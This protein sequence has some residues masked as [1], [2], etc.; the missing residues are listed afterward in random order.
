MSFDLILQCFESGEPEPA[1]HESVLNVLHKRCKEPPDNYGYYNVNFQDGS[2]VEFSAKGLQSSES[3]TGCSF[4]IR[5][6]SKELITFVYE[7]AVAGDMVIFNAQ[8]ADEPN[9]PLAL[10]IESRQSIDL[11]EGVAA[12]PVLCDSPSHLAELI[13]F[14]LEGWKDYRDSV[15]RKL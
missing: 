1:D 11:P 4:H 14:S 2:S 7:V 13:G 3:F 8:G 5:G 12:N 15:V 9:N 10:L 6:A